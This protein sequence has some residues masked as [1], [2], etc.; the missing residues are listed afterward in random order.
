SSSL[1]LPI[2]KRYR[3]ISELVEDTEDESSDSE[4]EREGS[5]GKSH[6]LEDEGPGLGY[7]ALRRRELAL[8]EGL[9]PRQSSRSVPEHA[10]AERISAFRQPTIVTWVDPEDDRVYTDILT[11]V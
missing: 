11:Y 9:V 6:D 1:T 2:R 8:G 7:E 10:G 3:G 5:E 4:T